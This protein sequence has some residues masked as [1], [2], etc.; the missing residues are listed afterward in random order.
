[1]K[2]LQSFDLTGRVAL[3]TGSARGIGQSIA[4]GLAEAGANVVL[5][6]QADLAETASLIEQS[7]GRCLA[8][9]RNLAPMNPAIAQEIISLAVDHFGSMDI[10]VNNAGI[11]RRSPA[12]EFSSEDWEEVLDINLNTVFYLSQAAAKYYVLAHKEGKIINVASMLSFQGGMYVSSYTASKSGIMGLT[13]ALANEWASLG[14]NVNA[15]AP[16]YLKTE[17]TAG[18]RSDPERNQAILG[19]IPAKRWGKPDDIKG[20]VI[21]LASAAAAYL[22]GVILPVDGGWLAR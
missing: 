7:G 6:D 9:K 19:R 16:G 11:I 5:L 17:V 10:L 18:I 3:V 21:F 4:I 20:A 12:I 1:M 13:K 22:H 14:I 8:E 2:G 15:I